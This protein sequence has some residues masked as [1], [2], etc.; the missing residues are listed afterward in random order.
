MMISIKEMLRK[1]MVDREVFF[2]VLF[3]AKRVTG[4]RRAA[5]RSLLTRLLGDI[6]YDLLPDTENRS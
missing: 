1:Y 4:A 5:E 2:I 6:A 3:L